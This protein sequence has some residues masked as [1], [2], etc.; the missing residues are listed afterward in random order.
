MARKV[1]GKTKAAVPDVEELDSP[2]DNADDFWEARPM[3]TY[4]RDLARARRVSPWALL[5][6]TMA[7]AVSATTYRVVLPPLVGGYGSINLAVGLV[8]APGAGKG[9]AMAVAK[10]LVPFEVNKAGIG[11]GEGVAHLYAERSGGKVKRTSQ[12]A[13]L[14]VA[15]IDTLRGMIQ[16]QGSTILPELRKAW[17]GESLGFA[18]ADP[19]KKLPIEEHTY[20]TVAVSRCGIVLSRTVM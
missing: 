16:R 7:Y 2:L 10:G 6:T 18:Y 9:A 8:G 4:I 14:Y 19:K 13:L 11:S 1:T 20:S 17:S 15:E 5:G 12:E 3:L